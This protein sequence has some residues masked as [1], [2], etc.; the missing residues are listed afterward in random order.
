MARQVVVCPG[1]AKTVS[2]GLDEKPD[3][4][5]IDEPH[6]HLVDALTSRD[7]R[8]M[9]TAFMRQREAKIA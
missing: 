1:A 9:P 8:D 6:N 4:M 7:T 3:P 2:G 5:A